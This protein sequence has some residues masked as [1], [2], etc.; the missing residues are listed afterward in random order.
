ML[1]S[2][3]PPWACCDTA[4]TSVKSGHQLWVGK[5]HQRRTETNSPLAAY[6]HGFT[7]RQR[8]C[9]DGSDMKSYS[10]PLQGLPIHRR[11][12]YVLV[13]WCVDISKVVYGVKR[14]LE[15]LRSA[16]KT[17]D[18]DIHRAMLL[19]LGRIH[20]ARTAMLRY[21]FA[22]CTDYYGLLSC[23]PVLRDVARSCHRLELLFILL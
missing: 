19:T 18:E 21:D 16:R 7:I 8:C 2:R 13:Y 11:P 5:R 15:R 20:R 12:D 3:S 10:Q 6:N 23:G 17:G 1:V 4:M 22:S 9:R 14:E